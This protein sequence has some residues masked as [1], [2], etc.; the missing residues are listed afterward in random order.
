MRNAREN[1]RA[2]SSYLRLSHYTVL[3]ISCVGFVYEITVFA[4]DLGKQ[5]SPKSWMPSLITNGLTDCEPRNMSWKIKITSIAKFSYNYTC[6]PIFTE[7]G[8]TEKAKISTCQ[9]TCRNIS[10]SK[11]GT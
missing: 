7:M 5:M 3:R 8:I 11:T 2:I 4:L 1:E 10:F 9:N 6:I